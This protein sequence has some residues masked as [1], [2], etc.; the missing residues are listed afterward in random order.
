MS[1]TFI[2][3]LTEEQ[4]RGKY[5]LLR[6]DFDVPMTT[7]EGSAVSVVRSDLK[8]KDALPTIKFLAT[9]GAKVVI[10]SHLDQPGGRVVAKYSL[11]PVAKRL[12]ELL[13]NDDIAVHFVSSCIVHK[14]LS[15]VKGL[16]SGQVL[17]LQNLRFHV[18][19]EANNEQFAKILAKGIDYYVNDA[20]GLC[21]LE[22]ASIVGVPR[23]IRHCYTGFLLR[24]ELRYLHDS[25]DN[26][27]RP[28]AAVIGGAKVSSKIGVMQHLMPRIDKL[29]VGGAMVYTFYRAIGHTVGD[30]LVEEDSLPEVEHILERAKER[31]VQI[32][33]A[34]D[35][36]ITPATIAIHP[37]KALPSSVPATEAEMTDTSRVSKGSL[38]QNVAIAATA[39]TVAPSLDEKGTAPLHHVA[40]T[41]EDVVTRLMKESPRVAD[42]QSIPS[43]WLGADIGPVSINKFAAE[44]HD[45]RTVLWK[46][47]MGLVENPQFTHGTFAVADMITDLTTR[48]AMTIVCGKSTVHTLESRYGD[49][50]AKAD[51]AELKRSFSHVSSGGHGVSVFLQGK[52]L[53]GLLALVK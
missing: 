22:H 18:E 43:G 51:G 32:V 11:E 13:A 12:N 31:N 16:Q 23:F 41:D 30:S 44:L 37:R 34:S 7:E 5:V 42:N 45:C 9:S 10:C 8:L 19:E 39:E 35:S 46:G 53:P 47:P 29:L 28:V 21:H 15:A 26:P 33:L 27:H 24:N 36:V 2:G 1:E 14:S 50:S 38:P 49:S 4:L 52:Q 40:H 6:T 48:G 17:L 25:L 20:L 3:S